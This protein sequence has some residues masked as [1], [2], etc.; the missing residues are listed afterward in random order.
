MQSGVKQAYDALDPVSDSTPVTSWTSNRFKQ[1]NAATPYQISV[2]VITPAFPATMVGN[3]TSPSV[4]IVSGTAGQLQT[5]ED[6][7]L[8]AVA[9]DTTGTTDQK[10]II[11]YR[12]LGADR[13]ELVLEGS[14][15]AAAQGDT[16]TII[17]PTDLDYPTAPLFFVPAGRTGQNAYFGYYLYNETLNE[18]RTITE[19][20]YFT[21]L[22]SVN[23]STSTIGTV[24]AGPVTGW[25]ATHNYSIRKQIPYQPSFANRLLNGDIANNPA[26]TISFNLPSSA[27]TTELVGS[28]LQITRELASTDSNGVL[29][30]AITQTSL[31]LAAAANALDGFFNGC[32]IRMNAGPGVG[33][34][35]TITAYN[36]TTKV[37]TIF[38]GFTVATLPVAG[39]AYF[40]DAPEQSRRIVKYVDERG[41]ASGS[42]VATSITLPASSSSTTNY[43]TNLYI[44]ILSGPATG[45]IRLIQS[46]DGTTKV[47]TPYN[48]FSAVVNAGNLYS[49]TS[50]IVSPGFSRSIA[51]NP[52]TIEMFSYDNAVPL[53]YTGS[54]VSQQEMVC[55]EIKLISLTLPNQT[56]DAGFGSRITYYPNVYVEFTNVSAASSGNTGIIYS[57]NP[58]SVKKLFTAAIDDVPNP[59]NS[60][61]LKIDGDGMTQTIKFKPNDALAFSVTLPSGQEFKTHINDNLSPLPPNALIQVRAIFSIRRL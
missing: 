2:T 11:G 53:N 18:Y 13:A 58:N 23:T 55:Y 29:G 16:I 8:N 47:A 4:I 49:I 42:G 19:Y 50:G 26:T 14:F 30:A 15:S 9:R 56:L 45:D 41:S 20:S 32:T 44:T 22:L 46:Y 40:I 35:N 43:Y 33:Q 60:T 28:F 34:I 25:L 61:F 1:N 17:D 59:I 3:A 12:Y 38:P 57:N 24:S 37:A 36:G 7:Y 52:F 27:S 39:N 31:E 48:N 6:Y 10:R 5:I 21:H 51:V 54:T